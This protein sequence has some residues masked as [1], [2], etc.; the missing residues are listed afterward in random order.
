MSSSSEEEDRKPQA[1]KEGDE[2]ELV[3]FKKKIDL[4]FRIKRDLEKK[5][6]SSIM[7]LRGKS[8]VNS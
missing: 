1:I 4:T 8:I 2:N 7:K 3:D 5:R 6:K